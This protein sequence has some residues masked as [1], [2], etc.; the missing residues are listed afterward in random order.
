MLLFGKLVWLHYFWE[1]RRIKFPPAFCFFW[2]ISERME[3]KGNTWTVC[4]G[5]IFLFH[6]GPGNQS[7]LSMEFYKKKHFEQFF[8]LAGTRPY[9]IY[10]VNVLF[11]LCKFIPTW[12]RL[13]L[14]EPNSSRAGQGIPRILW[15][16]QIHY[17]FQKCTFQQR[18]CIV[19]RL[20]NQILLQPV[21]VFH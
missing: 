21:I 13:L 11:R 14:L 2:N 5:L 6:L 7:N 19:R 20:L 17:R 1:C 12:S 18:N 9:N 3:A 10:V 4:A 8:L 16:P 15:N